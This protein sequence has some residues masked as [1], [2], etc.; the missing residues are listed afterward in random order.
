[1]RKLGIVLAVLAVVFFALLLVIDR[2]ATSKARDE[3]ATLSQQWGRPVSIGSVSI[4][5]LTGLGVRVE[6]V[7]VGPGEGEGEPLAQ[8]KQ[9]EVKVALLKAAFSR[10]K[11]IEV[12]S[13]E[14]DGLTVN[15]IRLPDGTTN[16][17]RLQKKISPEPAAKK[18]AD[19][20][21]PPGDFSFLR[22]D[23]LALREGKIALL[24]RSSPGKEHDLA[25]NHFDVTVNDL[26]AGSP[27]EVVVKAALLAEQQNFELHMKAAPL[28]KSLTP[29]PTALTLKVQPVDLTPL[30]PF[31]GKEVGLQAGKLDADFAMQLGAAVPGG[32]GPTSIKGA[33]HALGMRFAGS[34]GGKALDVV[35]DTDVNGDAAKGDLAIDKLRIDLGPAGISGTGRAH[36]I[37]TA[38]PQIEGLAITSHDLD[39]AKLAAY[40]PP[41][42][43]TI[44]SQISG[45]IGLSLQGGGSKDA[46]SLDLT[47]DL[48]PVRLAI[49]AQLAKAAGATMT[50]TA[51]V[52][53]AAASNG[54]VKFNLKADLAGVDLRPGE[55][56]DKAPAQRLDL[57]ISGTRSGE[58]IDLADLKAH[59]LDDELEGHGTADLSGGKKKFELA[60]ASSHLD[61]DKL[62]LPSKPKAKEEK[63][64]LDP[65]TFEGIDG[66][67]TV[68][69]DKLTMSKQVM[70]GIVAD[71]LMH[72]DDIKVTK[73]QLTA[74]GGT[75][76]ASGT[77][78]WLAHPK[79][80]F[81]VITHM[82]GIELENAMALFTPRKLLAGKFNGNIDLKGGGQL[83]EE[84]I[85]TLAG[86]LDG[87]VLDGTFFGKDLIGSVTGPLTK[88]LPSALSGKVTQ[89]GTTALG[90]D[91]PMGIRFAN[92]VAQLS[93]PLSITRP[94]ANMSF[95]G[96]INLEGTVDLPGKIELTPATISQITGGKVK[97]QGNIPFTVHLTGPAWSP[98][99]QDLDLK[100]AVSQIVKEAGANLL[101]KAIGVDLGGG[102][103]VAKQGTDQAKARA[104]DEAAK[105]QKKLQD[106][107]ANRLKGIFGK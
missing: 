77:E 82:T 49:P 72:D 73:A 63:P 28:P 33:L 67:A 23:H 5:L 98:Q 29:T 32:T 95:T 75:A 36:G 81:H 41:I 50:L 84:L 48:T 90:H 15:V 51:S 11:D 17:E 58:K 52:R 107:A 68:R 20:N 104:Q 101:G 76:D 65:K 97:V 105:A 42:R 86:Q 26:R 106:E 78:L 62:L 47:V 6:D 22:V 100:P 61:L 80:P 87:H 7:L 8:V 60:L 85:K 9:I 40:Y 46:Q 99:V 12:H 91:L 79:E 30:G 14:V 53:G 4:K 18:P 94:E 70:T 59:V 21:A 35:V 31:L 3:A 93:R 102:T 2:V 38:T 69:I 16:L 66:H 45:P 103:D 89:G 54:P 56:L 55:S 37:N 19:P 39:P 74:F 10:G 88:A 27:L 34:E 57:A 83:K 96:G 64:P 25:I 13:A 1:M 71:V 43:K 92:G 24:D 44:G